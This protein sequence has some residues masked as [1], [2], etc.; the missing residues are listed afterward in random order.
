MTKPVVSDDLDVW[1]D[2]L[3]HQIA[4]DIL[5]PETGGRAIVRARKGQGLFKERVSEIETKCRI[6]AAQNPIHLIA[7]HWLACLIW[8]LINSRMFASR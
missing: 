8:P 4:S 2:R 6:T 3:E 7:S 1:E 5:V